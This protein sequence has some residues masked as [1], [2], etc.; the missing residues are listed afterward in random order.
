MCG[1]AG[2]ACRDARRPDEAALRAMAEAVAH[3]GPDDAGQHVAPGI[4]LASRRL[5]ILD[6]SPAG[7]MPMLSADGQ[8]VLSWN[9]EIYNHV[10]LREELKRRGVRFR[11]SGDTE[12]LLHLYLAHG[13]DFLRRLTGMFAIAL[14]DGRRRVLLLARDRL[15]VKPLVY[16]LDD[17]GIRFASEIAGLL[18]EPGFTPDLDPVAIHHALA[19]RFIPGPNTAYASI[20]Q[21]PPAHV[22][23][24]ENGRARLERYWSL[25]EAQA[26]PRGRPEEW[27][28]RY[29]NLMD[30]AVRIRLRSDVPVALLLS[31]G[32]DSTAVAYH[33]RRNH[34][35]A[36]GAFCLGLE[37]ADYDERPLA[38]DTAAYF[39]IRLETMGVHENVVHTLAT[40]VGH[41]KAPFADPSIVPSWIL[42]REVSRHVKVALVGDGG[43][44]NFGGYDRY[45]AHLLADRLGWLPGVVSRTPFYALLEAVSSEKTRRNLPGRLR[46]FLDGWEL[47]ARE[48]NALWMA[49]PGAR[50][51]A[52]LYQPDFAARVAGID[53]TRAL[54]M[55]P[56]DW[57]SP[58]LIERVLRADL[59]H[60]LPDDLL[61]KADITSMAFG[62]ELRSPFLDHRVVEFAA[63]LPSSFKVRGRGGKW[64]LRRVYRG[65]IP[66]SVRRARKKGFGLP[67]DHW[68]RS[69]L[70]VPAHDLLLGPG[71][72]SREYLGPEAVAA[73]LRIH[74]LGQ[75]NY[76]EMIWTLL[77]LELWL[78]SRR[79]APAREAA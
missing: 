54:G 31:G 75:R 67:I 45:R 50:R 41:L 38:R 25:P 4:G 42:A 71:A 66:E 5:A 69:G 6:L 26:A 8:V 61:F 13:P 60:Y 48:R 36:F 12:V 56:N 70:H 78:R 20:L 52:R 35:G 27:E 65:H 77:V 7:H 24:Y 33:V 57:G 62:L 10:E 63:S 39:G 18:A 28:E 79:A 68:F 21:V 73:V 34:A 55:I 16:R 53:A 43:D 14:W 59:L 23:F 9:G 22:L 58:A 1:L 37:E 15:G 44:E 76:D 46:R 64:F 30:D 11:S 17:G 2:I 72:L 40:I 49:N 32:I 51:I 29:R 47:P 19:L 74:R 3:R